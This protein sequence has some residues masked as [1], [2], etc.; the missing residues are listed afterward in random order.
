M[1]NLYQFPI[2]SLKGYN[3]IQIV[4]LQQTFSL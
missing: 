3:I 1:I 2:F 4:Q